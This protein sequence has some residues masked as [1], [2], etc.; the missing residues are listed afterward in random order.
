MIA[1]VGSES[2]SR[3]LLQ[4]S[5]HMHAPFVTASFW[6]RDAGAAPLHFMKG[7]CTQIL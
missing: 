7:R 4:V 3:N 2:E 6:A 1:I 5:R